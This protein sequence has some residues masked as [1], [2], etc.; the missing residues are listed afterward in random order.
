MRTG[1]FKLTMPTRR[2]SVIFTVGILLGVLFTTIFV[3]AQSGSLST[4]TIA[5][6]PY[7]GA[8]DY[9]IFVEDGVYYA[10]DKYG[11]ISFTSTNAS[12]VIQSS[13]DNG[14]SVFVKNGNYTLTSKLTIDTDNHHIEG[15]SSNVFFISTLKPCLEIDGGSLD[16]GSTNNGHVG[17]G[18]DSVYSLQDI[19]MTNIRFYYTGAVETGDFLV[20]HGLQNDYKYVGENKFENI[21]ISSNQSTIP[22]DTTFVGLNAHDNV[23]VIWQNLNIQF[24]GTGYFDQDIYEGDMLTFIQAQIS[25]CTRGYYSDNSAGGSQNREHW[26]SSKLMWCTTAYTAYI[27]PMSLAFESSQFESNTNSINVSVAQVNIHSSVFSNYTNAILV[28]TNYGFYP[29]MATANIQDNKF[30]TGT[31]AITVGQTTLYLSGNTYLPAT[32]T[33]TTTS[34]NVVINN[35]DPN[36]GLLEPIK[37]SPNNF[38]Y[39]KMD[40]EQTVIIDSSTHLNN[41]VNNGAVLISGRVGAGL[42]LNGTGAYIDAGANVKL[43]AFTYEC[44]V[45]R[46]GDGADQ[47]LFSYNNNGGQEFRISSANY[48]QL[49]KSNTASVAVSNTTVPQNAWSHVALTYDAVGNWNFYLNGTAVGSGTSVQTWTMTG[50]LFLGAWKTN[51]YFNGYIDEVKVY[52]WALPEAEII[53][54]FNAVDAIVG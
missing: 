29:S 19:T 9:T 16:D 13:I 25:Y 1:K 6:G 2:V 38:L 37:Y 43:S 33:L 35:N 36:R 20:V 30:G 22:A 23:G 52:S 50:N 5:G 39:Y 34:N 8:P 12:Y 41:G 53:A 31:N 28:D 21:I 17:S 27:S 40:S 26:I 44:W 11:A 3:Q 32:V 42:S 4:A 54:N 18:L 45:Y 7:P 10:K 15:E 46:V 14:D 48:L 24:F 49:L 47:A 51:D